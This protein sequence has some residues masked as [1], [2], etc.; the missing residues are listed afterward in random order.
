MANFWSFVDCMSASFCKWNQASGTYTKIWNA[1]QKA[2]A[3]GEF[4]CELFLVS[5]N[6]NQAE[7]TCANLRTLGYHARVIPWE[8][9]QIRVHITWEP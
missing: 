7:L 1:M 6:S 3:A 5:G 4:S 8:K 2:Q 9:N